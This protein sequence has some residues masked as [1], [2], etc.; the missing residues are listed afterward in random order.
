MRVDIFILFVLCLVTNGSRIMPPPLATT[1]RGA[2]KLPTI[3]SLKDIYKQ[4]KQSNDDTVRSQANVAAEEFLQLSLSHITA[5]EAMTIINIFNMNGNIDKSIELLQ[6]GIDKTAKNLMIDTGIFNNVLIGIAKSPQHAH[7]S[8]DILD[9]MKDH[10]VPRD[11]ITYSAVLSSLAK[12]GEWEKSISLLNTMP[13]HEGLTPDKVIYSSVIA[14][15]ASHGKWELSLELLR[16]M[17]AHAVEVDV[18]AFNSIIN[19]CAQA[20]QLDV[21]L[22][23][24]KEYNHLAFDAYTYSSAIR[25]CDLTDNYKMAVQLL[26]RMLDAGILPRTAVPFNTAINVCIRNKK[27]Q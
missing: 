11:L 13:L 8:L 26:Q 10:G 7:L 15:C 4:S 5:K 21:I 24:M 9:K 20:S 6:N 23:L 17:E 16:Q 1:I 3:D 22:E 18:I 19:A 27:I 25:A 2:Y 12:L 14:A